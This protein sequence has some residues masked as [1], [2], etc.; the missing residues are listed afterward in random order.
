MNAALS[1]MEERFYRFDEFQVDPVRRLL[2]RDGEV[3]PITPKALAILV[4]LLER[5]GK[6]V[7]K[8]DLIRQVWGAGYVSDANLTQNISFAR[9]A[10]GERAGDRRYIVTVPGQG[11]CFA[12]PI[13]VPVQEA[14]RPAAAPETPE[15]VAEPAAEISETSE[16]STGPAGSEELAAAPAP[17]SATPVARPWLRIGIGV[18]LLILVLGLSAALSHLARGS[19]APAA[20]LDAPTIPQRPSIAVLGFKNLSG[21]KKTDWLGSALAEMLTTE[22]ATGS[23]VRVISRENVSRARGALKI[24]ASGT[25]DAASL[26]KIRNIVG[27]DLLVS[28]SYLAL[29]KESGNRIR[30]D[31]RVAQSSGDLVASLADVGSDRELFEMVTR[32]GAKLRQALGFVEPSPEQAQA[33]RALHPEGSEAVRLYA[34][35]LERLQSYD[36]P[37]ALELLRQAAEADPGS[38]VI[39]AAL[40][41]AL[42]ELGHDEQAAAEAKRAVEL[43]GALPRDAR[44]GIEALSYELSKQWGRASEIYSSLRTFY[45]DDLDYGLQLGTSLMMSGRAREAREMLSTLRRLPLPQGFDP[46]IDLLEASVARRLSDVAGQRRAAEAAV[47][48]GW[49]SGERLMVAQGLVFQG[50][51][52]HNEGEPRKATGLLR[53]AK[54]LAA[55][56]GH[57][58][59]TG[60]ALSNLGTALQALGDLDGAEEAQRESLAIAER[61]GSASG[62]AA[63]LQVLGLL[64]QERGELAKA[65]DHL[66]RSRSRYVALG[67]RMMEARSLNAISRVQWL[68]GDFAGARGASERALRI[69]RDIGSRREEA[70]AL[71]QLGRILVWLE[72]PAEALRRQEEAFV[73]FRQIGDPSQAASAL[74]DSAGVIAAM[75]DLPAARRRYRQ[76]LLTKRRVGDRVGMAEILDRLA[77]LAHREG[78][79]AR[80][81]RLSEWELRIVEE[82]GA[83]NLLAKALTRLGRAEWAAGRFAEA[84]VSLERSLALSSER[85][86]EM[87]ELVIHLYLGGLALSERRFA[88]AAGL[89]RHAA[90]GYR[91][92]GVDGSETQALSLLAEALLREGKLP[93]ARQ[94]AERAR[95]LVDEFDSHEIH[96]LVAS[97]VAL[98]DAAGGEADRAVRELRRHL[99]QAQ[100]GGYGNVALQARLSLGEVLLATDA[101]AGRATLLEVQKEAAD[102]GFAEL[103]QRAGQA[104]ETGGA[105]AGW[106]GRRP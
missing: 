58:F 29:G 98:V 88:D 100:A 54:E 40:A 69:S 43:S 95:A 91:A 18:A 62:I 76:A 23:R 9:K 65:L 78:D 15:M 96:A 37:R 36:A 24:P 27:A 97:R 106:T 70:V 39:R 64:Y 77:G 1:P 102:R 84:R 26:E 11:Y 85:D 12:A 14:P 101:T 45:P 21:E 82:T 71:N 47:A 8:E 73:L 44:L 16:R 86:E 52:L 33:A 68:Q 30:L 6:V 60:M 63:Q 5:Q 75:R 87:E 32:T 57:L 66:E 79:I 51:A 55:G 103:S 22:L 59:I 80:S 46:R 38:A 53:Q 48:K 83:H 104:L 90:E 25:L 13:T 56:E 92:H 17:A 105:L 50:I 35:G 2:L 81:R 41:K 28:G 61:I 89:A 94:A 99:A 31:V 4:V 49:H 74:A 67:D 93:E 20:D 34:E 10:L 3:I 72:Q 7:A 19:L 42:G